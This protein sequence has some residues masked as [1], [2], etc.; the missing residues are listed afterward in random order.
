MSADIQRVGTF[1]PLPGMRFPSDLLAV[2]NYVGIVGATTQVLHKARLRTR[3]GRAQWAL[4]AREDDEIYNLKSRAS[5]RPP[6][7]KIEGHGTA[8]AAF[9][10]CDQAAVMYPPSTRRLPMNRQ[11]AVVDAAT[12]A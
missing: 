6:S 3:H 5:D 4:K 10:D 12:G 11:D 1:F 7:R 9:V 8:I 2:P